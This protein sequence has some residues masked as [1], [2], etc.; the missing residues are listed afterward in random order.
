MYQ[1]GKPT[2]ETAHSALF[3]ITEVSISSEMQNITKYFIPS[4]TYVHTIYLIFIHECLE[5]YK[6]WKM[7]CCYIHTHTILG[8][9]HQYVEYGMCT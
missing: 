1:V 5:V 2:L 4:E 8:V 9:Y 3:F 6:I 7:F